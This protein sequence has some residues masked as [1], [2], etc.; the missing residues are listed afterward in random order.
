MPHHN[1]IGRQPRPFSLVSTSGLDSPLRVVRFS[2][3]SPMISIQIGSLPVPSL[4]S[5][6]L[7]LWMHEPCATI[8]RRTK[9]ECLDP[10]A[11]QNDA[12]LSQRRLGSYPFPAP[13]LSIIFSKQRSTPRIPGLNIGRRRA[14]RRRPGK[15]M[16]LLE[17]DLYCTGW[18]MYTS[19]LNLGIPRPSSGAMP[20]HTELPFVSATRA[21][22]PGGAQSALSLYP[23]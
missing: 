5:A 21:R 19:I 6:A 8:C 10:P 23:G 18:Y 22:S 13:A 1:S 11:R 20:G 14:L 4:S 3:D 2:P 17:F 15:C 16:H 12:R 9:R 7:Q